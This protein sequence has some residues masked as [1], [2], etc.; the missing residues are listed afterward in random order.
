[1]A[2][3]FFKTLCFSLLLAADLAY[4]S[5]SP[6]VVIVKNVD[7]S[8]VGASD[9]KLK[10]EDS[11]F[12]N[13]SKNVVNLNID[14]NKKS[15]SK[16]IKSQLRNHLRINSSTYLI[17]LGDKSE[18]TI[19]G[20]PRNSKKVVTI[21]KSPLPESDPESWLSEKIGFDAIVEKAKPGKVKAFLISPSKTSTGSNAILVQ[22][23][24]KKISLQV[25]DDSFKIQES[26]EGFGLLVLSS[27]KG[28]T[29]IFKIVYLKK[30]IE[31]IPVGTKI[32][33]ER[34][35]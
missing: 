17:S 13:I 29:G 26:K 30:G 24:E 3:K 20:L 6:S 31:T 1:M 34:D 21:A 7:D 9:P 33:I 14:F 25:V 12:K 2:L 19:Y 18:A 22:N 5:I 11:F 15:F 35:D 4:G 10:F 32:R 8:I 28:S 27:I 16:G 23:S